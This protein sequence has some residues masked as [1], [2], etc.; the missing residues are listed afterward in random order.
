MSGTQVSIRAKLLLAFVLPLAVVIPGLSW[1]GYGVVREGFEQ[2]L[3]ARL[4]AVARSIATQKGIEYVKTLAAGDDDVNTARNI[5]ERLTRA[6][7]ATGVARAY[8]FDR[9]GRALADS[10]GG[11]QLRI[12][13]RIFRLEQ[14][15]L[16]LRSAW[17]AGAASSLLFQ[18]ENGRY[19][20]TGYARL[21]A[22]ELGEAMVAVQGSPMYFERLDRLLNQLV[23]LNAIV[24]LGMAAVVI[25]ASLRLTKPLFELKIAA[26]NIA[27]GDYRQPVRS[28]SSDE[29]GYLAATMETM[30]ASIN[31]R[32]EQMQMML[33]GI[34]HEVRNP[35][36]GIE[37]YAGL[38]HEELGN[39]P[40]LDD[41]VRKIQKELAYLNRVVNEFLDFARQTP[42]NMAPCDLVALVNE[43]LDLVESELSSRG[44][45][46]V[47]EAPQ[48]L[49]LRADASRLRQALLNLALNAI[50]AMS[51]GGQLRIRVEKSGDQALVEIRDN[52]KG[53]PADQ[54][55][56]LFTPFFTTR[57]KGTGLGLALVR[58]WVSEH[59]GSVRLESR[60]GEGA[61]VFLTL[62]LSPPETSAPGG[63]GGSAPGGWIG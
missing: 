18:D 35:L 14:D 56:R 17:E 43:V 25:W 22:G 62:P 20:K 4:I 5:Q 40:E 61:A 52:G 39:H 9:E 28:S 34:A 12:G 7:K 45:S 32:N 2:E 1:L 36:G 48:S 51:G 31:A 33:A 58:K 11:K 63:N 10:G 24:L 6:V 60:E 46:V 47:T 30:R 44:I 37:L 26:E 41:H 57:E 59:G 38:L 50:Q 29:I 49:E 3:G 54:L 16:E 13:D 55:P 8:I 42:P 15:K 19:L 53:V 23:V 27:R 21:D